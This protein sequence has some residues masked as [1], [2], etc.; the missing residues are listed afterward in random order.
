MSLSEYTGQHEGETCKG[1]NTQADGEGLHYDFGTSFTLLEDETTLYADWEAPTFKSVFDAANA[2]LKFVYD[3]VDYDEPE[4]TVVKYI[5]EDKPVLV[6]ES[7][8]DWG[9]NAA[10]KTTVKH[11]IIDGSL[12]SLPL[13]KIPY[14][15]YNM[16]ELEEVSGLENLNWPTITNAHCMFGNL[17]SLK[18]I[19]L[20]EGIFSA[21]DYY[22]YDSRVVFSNCAFTSITNEA[23]IVCSGYA[24]DFNRLWDNY[25]P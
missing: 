14:M 9:L 2:E 20:P 6:F 13:E 15:I 4:Y 11:L 5:N 1:W 12:K 22:D 18:H 8:E 3:K 16:S 24:L 25:R 19:T 23:P 21:V 7:A 10:T 17:D